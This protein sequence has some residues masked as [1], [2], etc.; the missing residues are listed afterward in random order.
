[1]KKLLAGL[2]IATAAIGGTALA[3]TGAS[4]AT[5]ANSFTIQVSSNPNIW[6]TGCTVGTS[7]GGVIE[8]VGKS[9][10]LYPTENSPLFPPAHL[11]GTYSSL[12]KAVAKVSC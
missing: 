9:Y 6:Q 5:S 2:A 10:D 8:Q 12:A 3:A 1:M 11:S 4:A 7:N